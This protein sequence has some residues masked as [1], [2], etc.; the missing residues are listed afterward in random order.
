MTW[1]NRAGLPFG[2]TEKRLRQT[3][4]LNAAQLRKMGEKA[5]S[6]GRKVNGYTAEQ[7]HERAFKKALTATL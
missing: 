1:T 6:T 5:Q 2:G 7:L 3:Y 4:I